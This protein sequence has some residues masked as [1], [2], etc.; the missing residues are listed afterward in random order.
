MRAARSILAA[1]AIA[2]GLLLAGC[3]DDEQEPTT[4][5][6]AEQGE[7]TEVEPPPVKDQR[8]K[9]PGQV[10]EAGVPANATVETSCGTFVIE[11]DTERSPKTANSF[12]FLAEQGFYDDTV[13]HRIVPEFVVQGGDP[14]GSDPSQAGG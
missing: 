8:F 11:L 5:T 3:G 10:L 2:A 1:S 6:A 14:A 4:T 12:A 7:C 13:F 9:K